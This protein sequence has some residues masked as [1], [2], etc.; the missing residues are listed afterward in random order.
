MFSHLSSLKTWFRKNLLNP[1]TG[2]LRGTLMP[3]LLDL[4]PFIADESDSGN[5]KLASVLRMHYPDMRKTLDKALNMIRDSDIPVGE[6][7][8]D[9]LQVIF[10][11][12]VNQ[13]REIV[14]AWNQQ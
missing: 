4:E 10:E 7:N 6:S 11:D 14:L 5:V 9:A 1:L 12:R 2:T 8:C 3:A 13:A